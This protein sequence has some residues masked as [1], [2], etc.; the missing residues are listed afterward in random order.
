MPIETLL[1]ALQLL[2]SLEEFLS[3][4][5]VQ[6]MLDD[7]ELID[8]ALDQLGKNADESARIKAKLASLIQA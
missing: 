8:K 3:N 1:L 6:A 2:G 5:Q 4:K 7:A